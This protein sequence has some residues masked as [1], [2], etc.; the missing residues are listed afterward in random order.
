MADGSDAALVDG[1]GPL[2]NQEIDDAVITPRPRGNA[3]CR[4]ARRSL[5][6][7]RRLNAVGEFLGVRAMSPLWK[8]APHSQVHNKSISRRPLSR[9]F[10]RRMVVF[11]A[12]ARFVN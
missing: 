11:H 1:L 5:I 8:E 2:G 9:D 10:L 6:S 12:K 4:R 7:E 3:A